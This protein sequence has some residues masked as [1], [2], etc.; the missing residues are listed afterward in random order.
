MKVKFSKKSVKFLESLDEKNRE[1]ALRMASLNT[2]SK[3]RKGGAKVA[4]ESLYLLKGS[5]EKQR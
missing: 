1:R 2:H 3:E 5:M 4:M